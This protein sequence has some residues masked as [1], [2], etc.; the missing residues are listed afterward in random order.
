LIF[1]SIKYRHADMLWF[2]RIVT[3]SEHSQNSS[4]DESFIWS[5]QSQ[6]VI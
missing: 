5:V 1:F 2:S 6:P 3:I 4:D